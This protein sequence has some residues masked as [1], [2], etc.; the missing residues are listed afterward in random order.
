MSTSSVAGKMAVASLVGL[1]PTLS[2]RLDAQGLVRALAETLANPSL[3]YVPIYSTGVECTRTA[4]VST[5]MIMAQTS[6]NKQFVTDNT[7]PQPRV[8]TIKGYL[9]SLIPYLEDRLFFKPTL[10][11]QKYIM[12]YSMTNREPIPFKSPDGE[13]V[14]VLIK[15]L[16]IITSP[17]NM[18]TA[19][20]TVDVQELNYLTADIGELSDFEVSSPALSVKSLLVS[21]APMTILAVGVASATVVA[22]IPVSEGTGQLGY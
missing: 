20:I 17:T 22:A 10:M 4:I 7:A 6:G 13:V 12:D 2:S 5:S 1:L 3:N 11:L 19:E 16:R 8:W 15:S 21:L 9:R 18:N 14:D